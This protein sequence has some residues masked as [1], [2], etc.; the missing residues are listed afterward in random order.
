MHSLRT[1]LLR[2]IG[3]VRV[4]GEIWRARGA[5]PLR[6]GQKIEVAE[7]DGLTLVVNEA[8]EKKTMTVFWLDNVIWIAVLLL[9]LFIVYASLGSCGNTNAALSSCSVD[10]G[11]SRVPA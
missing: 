7:V 9:G 8:P 2:Q 4:H 10:F 5:K 3:R 11:R 1:A 6:R